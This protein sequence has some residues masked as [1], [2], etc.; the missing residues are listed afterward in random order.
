MYDI[1]IRNGKI[2]DL[3]QNRLLEKDI[4]IKNKKIEKIGFLSGDSKLTI[5]ADGKYISPGF[6]DIHM[7][8][9]D[10]SLF[11]VRQGEKYDISLCMLRMGVTTA[12]AGNCGNNRQPLEELIENIR[13][14]RNPVHYMSYIGH[15]FLR[16]QAGR[17][18]RYTGA[19]KNE[20]RKMQL[21]VEQAIELGAIGIS[22]GLEYC[23]G[24][25]FE[26]ALAVAKPIFGREDILLSAHYRK[27]GSFAL[28]SIDEM[29]QLG[30]QAAVPFQ[31][32][33]LASCSGF[34]N[35]RESL[36]RIQSYVD[37]G[38][39][40]MADSYPY[41]AFSTYI[42]SSVFDEGCF[43]NWN[44]SYEAIVLTEEP[45]RGVRCTKE[46]F[47]TARREH[48]NMLAIVHVMNEEEIVEAIK[49]PLVLAASDGIYRNNAGHPRGA[50]TFPRILGK[51]CRDQKEL[52]LFDAVSKMTKLPA[53]R[54][55]L[56]RKGQ[57]IEGYD[58]DLTIFDY[59][60]I[61]DRASF[62]NPQLA[63]TGIDYVIIDGKIALQSGEIVNPHLGQF[64]SRQ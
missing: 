44:S 53:Q 11:P 15:N 41:D 25:D 20:I 35:M 22:Y 56:S 28:E 60:K 23:P 55:R 19:D 26:E 52:S 4:G 30:R 33:H 16:T 62:D 34:G 40:I 54:L 51:Y 3:Q 37:Q 10:Y 14:Y 63:P 13:H 12:V 27:D 32:S 48:P 50:G 57:I 9:E 17:T 8:E 38:E 43:E 39:N 59:K 18:D 42:G 31:I 36:E 7:H 29:V 21:M 24:I 61:I 64:I 58:A 5:D 49:H 6:I 1:A 47:E 2:I 46:I 45:F